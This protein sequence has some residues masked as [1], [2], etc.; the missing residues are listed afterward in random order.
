ML[1]RL[2]RQVSA[3]IIARLRLLPLVFLTTLAAIPAL[4]AAQTPTADQIQIFQNL[5]ADQQQSILG[6]LG[7]GAGATSAAGGVRSDRPVQFPNTVLPRNTNGTRG[8]A[9]LRDNEYRLKGEDTLLLSLEIRESTAPDS[10]QV[11]TGSGQPAATQLQNAGAQATSAVPANTQTPEKIERSPEQR[12]RL[13]ALREQILRRNPYKLDR[14]AVLSV[15]ELG[16]V[17]LGGLTIPEARQRIAAEVTLKDFVVGVTLLPLEPTGT[18]ALKPFGY[19]LFAGIPTTFAPAT[20]VPV[21][22]EYVVGPG[23]TLRVQLVGATRGRS[24]SRSWGPLP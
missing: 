18:A 14:G 19:D 2:T 15:L 23:D 16:P 17:Q 1:V 3:P 22:T 24:T 12:A 10:V 21:P 9:D 5:P 7:S 11:A 6:T 20:D 13:N 4:V 8:A